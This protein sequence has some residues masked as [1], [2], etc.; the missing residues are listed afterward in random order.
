MNPVSTCHTAILLFT[1][2]PEDEARIKRFGTRTRGATRISEALTRHTRQVLSQTGLP[3]FHIAGTRQ[4]GDTFGSRLGAAFESVFAAGYTRVIAVGNDT[5]TLRPADLHRACHL[6]S[7]QPAVWGPA[8][9]GG[10]WLLGLTAESY[11][12]SWF[13]TL[14]WETPALLQSLQAWSAGN[15]QALLALRHQADLDRPSDLPALLALLAPAQM[16]RRQLASLLLRPPA[17]SPSRDRPVSVT[18]AQ[19]PYLRAPPVA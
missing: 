17:P 8:T 10:V 4:T 6:L 19:L 13:V 16:V 5:P 15:G 12:R 18:P 14:P 2:H 7:T 11:A 1:R 3:V 9:D